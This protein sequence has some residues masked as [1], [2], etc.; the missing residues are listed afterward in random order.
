MAII[1]SEGRP[2][3]EINPGSTEIALSRMA[4]LKAI[5][6]LDNTNIAVL[7]GDIVVA[8]DERLRYADATWHTNRRAEEEAMAFAL[9]SRIAASDYVRGYPQRPGPQPLFVLVLDE[10][11][12]DRV[13]K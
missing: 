3:A 10:A 6:A 5:D 1:S 4:A 7:G 9:R 12:G 2:L 8:E 13:N 11:H